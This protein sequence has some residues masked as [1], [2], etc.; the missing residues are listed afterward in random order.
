MLGF[1]APVPYQIPHEHPRFAEA[2]S[3]LSPGNLRWPGGSVAN[4]FEWRSGQLVVPLEGEAS[5]YRRFMASMAGG[6]SRMHPN[7][8]HAKEFSA[9]AESVGAELVWV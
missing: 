9:V 2:V 6:S 4:F 3:L 7:G 8:S 5:M 1:N